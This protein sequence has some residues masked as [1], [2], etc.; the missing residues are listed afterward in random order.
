VRKG[1]RLPGLADGNFELLGRGTTGNAERTFRA[2]RRSNRKDQMASHPEGRAR[3][4]RIRVTKHFDVI[5]QD[6]P[7]ARPFLD[8]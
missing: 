7:Q 2:S 1:R 6:M 3:P 5:A 4:R 8:L